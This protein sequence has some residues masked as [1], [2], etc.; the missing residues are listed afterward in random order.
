MRTA[1]IWCR[2]AMASLYLVVGVLLIFSPGLEVWARTSGALFMG[3]T[4]ARWVAFDPMF[5]RGR[6]LHGFSM[7]RG[8]RLMCVTYAAAG[9]CALVALFKLNVAFASFVSPFLLGWTGLWVWTLRRTWDDAAWN[10]VSSP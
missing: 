9:G 1:W 10:E 5:S 3:G 2:R 7:A 4:S 6:R 8:F